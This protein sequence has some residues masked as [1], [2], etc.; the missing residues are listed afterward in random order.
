MFL[1]EW[2]VDVILGM[3]VLFAMGMVA[4]HIHR[5]LHRWIAEPFHKWMERRSEKSVRMGDE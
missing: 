3:L 4:P 5:R 2:W 1:F